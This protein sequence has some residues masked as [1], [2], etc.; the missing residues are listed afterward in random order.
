[1]QDLAFETSTNDQWI[2]RQSAICTAVLCLST[3]KRGSSI[4]LSIMVH[5]AGAF[6]SSSSEVLVQPQS[7][8]RLA[9]KAALMDTL[10]VQIAGQEQ[11]NVVQLLDSQ[12]GIASCVIQPDT[13]IQ[14]AQPSCMLSVVHSLTSQQEPGQHQHSRTSAED[15]AE[16]QAFTDA[17]IVSAADRGTQMLSCSRLNSSQRSAGCEVNASLQVGGSEHIC[18][19][20]QSLASKAVDTPSLPEGHIAALSAAGESVLMLKGLSIGLNSG[21]PAVLVS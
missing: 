21:E 12:H 19:L 6:Q 8:Q 16:V 1:M 15:R 10:G 17:T 3:Q 2:C 13:P 4:T 20:A 7:M 14:Q 11:H 9:A 18:Q 5:D